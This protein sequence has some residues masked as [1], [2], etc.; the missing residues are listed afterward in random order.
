MYI[1]APERSTGENAVNVNK[2]LKRLNRYVSE[3]YD[4]A[5]FR[6]EMFICDHGGALVSGIQDYGEEVF[7]EDFSDIIKGKCVL[8]YNNFWILT[9]KSFIF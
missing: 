8:F 3:L 7:N 4:G 6:P 1:E 5:S 9:L 2:M